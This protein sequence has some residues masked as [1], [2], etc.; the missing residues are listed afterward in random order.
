MRLVR[1][2][3][4]TTGEQDRRQREHS[5]YEASHVDRFFPATAWACCTKRLCQ[6]PWYGWRGH[7]HPGNVE[8]A[9]Q[10]AKRKQQ[11]DAHR[12]ARED[13]RQDRIR[14]AY[15]TVPRVA[16]TYNQVTAQQSFVRVSETAEARNQ[17]HAEA[18]KTLTTADLVLWLEDD[19]SEIIVLF[20]ELSLDFARR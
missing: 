15:V 8:G 14:D 2:P 19:K 4:N 13:A 11:E 9:A 5:C 16:V 10:T 12:R 17:R 3:Q 6:C 20:T 1:R 7:G 18:L